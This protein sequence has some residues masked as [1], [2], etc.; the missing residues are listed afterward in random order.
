V[1]VESEL[2]K[3]FRRLEA[4]WKESRV[5]FLVHKDLNKFQDL[6]KETKLGELELYL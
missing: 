6:S 5:G 1:E 4:S 3:N 2:E